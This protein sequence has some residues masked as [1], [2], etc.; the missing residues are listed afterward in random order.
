MKRHLILLTLVAAVGA[1]TLAGCGG[2]DAAPA[3]EPAAPVEAT[4]AAEPTE[5]APTIAALPDACGLLPQAEA[6]A[7][8]GTPLDPPRAIRDTCTYTGPVT[9]PTAQVEIYVGDGAKKFLDIDRELGH[10]FAEL[11]GIGD[12]AHLE[13]GTVFFAKGGVW[14]GIRVV[15]LVD[16]ATLAKPLE[17]AARAAVGRM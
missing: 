16:A 2:G 11:S 10:T 3:P 5:A 6:E 12:E 8:V 9:G 7:I 17:K 1:A 13:D 4:A 14:V 15:R